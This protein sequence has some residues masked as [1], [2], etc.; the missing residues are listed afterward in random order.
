LEEAFFDMK[1]CMYSLC[2]VV[3]HYGKCGGGHYA[4]Y[5]KAPPVNDPGL[6]VEGLKQVGN[7][8]WFYVSD[9]HVLEVSEE[10]VLSANAALLFYE[11]I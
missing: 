1:S 10:A 6:D 9:R 8:K 7:S 5:R 2:A 3:E 11:R 4:A